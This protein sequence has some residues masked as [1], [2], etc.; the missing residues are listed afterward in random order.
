MKQTTRSYTPYGVTQFKLP[1]AF[2]TS[3]SRCMR[4]DLGQQDSSKKSLI[5]A[6]NVM[7]HRRSINDREA[8]AHTHTRHIR[9]FNPDLLASQPGQAAFNRLIAPCTLI[10]LFMV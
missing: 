1:T 6:V 10:L 4:L 2:D 5:K 3:I 9:T 7:S 8:H